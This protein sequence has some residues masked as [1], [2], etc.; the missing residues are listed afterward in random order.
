MKKIW[1]RKKISA[2]TKFFVGS[3]GIL[4][5]LIVWITITYVRMPVREL[6]KSN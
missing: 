4:L 1:I 2:S 5:S 6:N 3:L